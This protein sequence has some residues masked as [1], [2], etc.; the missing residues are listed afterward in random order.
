MAAITGA[1]VAAPVSADAARG[2]ESRSATFQIQ[3]KGVQTTTWSA[4]ASPA[5]GCDGPVR[6]G[7]GSERITFRSKWVRGKLTTFGSRDA[8]AIFNRPS[9][10]K[11][12]ELTLSGTVTRRSKDEPVPVRPECAVADGDGTWEPSAPDCGTKRF[13]G[14]EVGPDVATRNGRRYLKVRQ[15]NR[16]K[17]P[18]F[19]ECWVQGFAWPTL[20]QADD[21]NKAGVVTRFEP[22]HVFDTPRTGRQIW[23]GRGERTIRSFGLVAKTKIEWSYTVRKVRKAR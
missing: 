15:L 5:L 14:L 10:T 4:D 7:R 18:G 9:G 8:V 2:F 23:I 20:L 17:Q 13:S 22:R 3:L 1:C 11:P 12:L 16:L 21:K 19:A 6:V